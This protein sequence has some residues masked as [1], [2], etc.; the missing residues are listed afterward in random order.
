M[1]TSTKEST[2]PERPKVK[3]LTRGVTAKCMMASGKTVRRKDMV[4]GEA[5]MATAT[6]VSGSITRLRAMGCT[7]GSMVTAMKANGKA[8]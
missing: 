4:F 8:A 7:P 5:S 3:A 2:L 6:L 1:A